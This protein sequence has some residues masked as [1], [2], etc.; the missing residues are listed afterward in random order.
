MTKKRVTYLAV[1]LTV[2]VAS[3]ASL[4]FISPYLRNRPNGFI[5]LLP[6]HILEPGTILDLKYNSYYIAGLTKDTIY[7]ANHTTPYHLVEIDYSLQKSVDRQ[8]TW[9]RDIKISE[10]AIIT[11][12]SPDVYLNDG[13][14]ATLFRTKLDNINQIS[15]FQTPPFTGS[16]NITDHSIVC[17]CINS[18]KENVLV[19]QSLGLKTL[20]INEGLIQKQGDGIFSTDGMLSKIP[21]TSNIIYTYHY[22]NQFFCADS[23]LNLQYR[24]KTVDT[25]S[26]AHI[27]VAEIKSDGAITMSSPPLMVNRSCC[28]SEKYLFINSALNANNEPHELLDKLLIIDVYNIKDG[29]YKFSFYLPDAVGKKAS[30]FKVYG[31]KLVAIYDHYISVYGLNFN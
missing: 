16:A 17:R 6:S 9:S 14:G 10:A 21:G 25:V 12:D 29:K 19:K 2:S 28:A 4:Y 5:R 22:R 1:C 30:D 11:V 31:N 20:K 13:F 23:N 18:R 3:V 26:H 15:V 24:G 27:T 8:I 7:L